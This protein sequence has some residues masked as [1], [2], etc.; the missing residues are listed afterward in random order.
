MDKGILSF[1]LNGQ[2][3]G[4]AYTDKVLQSGPIYPCIALLH[5]AGCKVQY[6]GTIPAIFKWKIDK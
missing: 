4:V 1:S 5:E 2:F 6:V 3:L